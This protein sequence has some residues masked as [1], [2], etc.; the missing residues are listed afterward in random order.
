MQCVWYT[1][2]VCRDVLLLRLAVVMQPVQLDLNFRWTTGISWC[3]VSWNIYILPCQKLYSCH[4]LFTRQPRPPL[5]VCLGRQGFILIHC[6]PSGSL[7]KE[8]AVTG[9]SVLLITRHRSCVPAAGSR[10][11]SS[12][13]SCERRQS[14]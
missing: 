13:G 6:V 3:C 2:G 9:L 11:D 4:L 5:T 8:T 14:L 10:V 12:V 1:H 7:A